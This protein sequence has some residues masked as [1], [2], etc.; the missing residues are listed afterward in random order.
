MKR[1]I[2]TQIEEMA[3]LYSLGMLSPAEAREFETEI[4]GGSEKATQSLKVFD[5]L[6]AGLALSVPEAAPSLGIRDV[7]LKRIS[8]DADEQ[9]TMFLMI[10]PGE[11][12]IL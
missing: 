5:E 1:D 9:G 10:S 12:E 8:S 6:V 11:L 7:L 2:I 4:A 3:A